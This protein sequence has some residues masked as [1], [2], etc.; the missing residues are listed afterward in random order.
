MTYDDSVGGPKGARQ[1]WYVEFCSETLAE[2]A[3]KLDRL[4]P[5][6]RAYIAKSRTHV[7]GSLPVML[8]RTVD[9]ENQ[10]PRQILVGYLF[11]KLM[12]PDQSNDNGGMGERGTAKGSY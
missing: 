12:I 7:I 9:Q 8:L 11:H 2:Q 6:L 1:R 3:T 4:D 5:I 10:P